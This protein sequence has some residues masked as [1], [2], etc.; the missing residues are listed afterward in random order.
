MQDYLDIGKVALNWDEWLSFA[1]V[2]TGVTLPATDLSMSYFNGTRFHMTCHK[3]TETTPSLTRTLR[4]LGQD[5]IISCLMI[6]SR[7]FRLGDNTVR[8]NIFLNH[9]YQAL[10]TSYHSTSFLPTFFFFPPPLPS[11]LFLLL[12]LMEVLLD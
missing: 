3:H 4:R 7:R 11:S 2:W 10:T 6:S 12:F 5:E 8:S 1:A 9:P